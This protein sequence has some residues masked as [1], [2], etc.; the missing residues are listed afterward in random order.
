MTDQ[1]PDAPQPSRMQRLKEY[2]AQ[3]EVRFSAAFFLA[4]FLFD[5]VTLSS[6]DDPFTIIQ[7]VVYLLILNV[8]LMMESRLE[9]QGVEPPRWLRRAWPY[10]G[11]VVHFILGSLLSLYSLYFFKSASLSSSILFMVLMFAALVLNELPQFQKLGL[12]IRWSLFSLC[13]FSFTLTLM[14]VLFGHVGWLPFLASLVVTTAILLAVIHDLHKRDPQAKVVQ[15]ESV[16]P[17]PAGAQNLQSTAQ[18][19]TAGAPQTVV[20][21]VR[22]KAFYLKKLAPAFGV[23]VLFFVFYLFKILPPVP[24]TLQKVGVYHDIQKDSV[25][26]EYLLFRERPWWKFWQNGDQTFYARPGEKIYV[27]AAIYSPTSF[28]DQVYMTWMRKDPELGWQSWQRIPMSIAGGRQEGFRGYTNKAN[29][30]TGTWR[31]VIETTDGREIGR[32][33]FNVYRSDAP[34]E[35]EPER[36]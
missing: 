24:V 18:A 5:V 36:Y 19:P 35:T 8:L 21:E 14:P 10:H 26:D 6:P 3:H 33:Q 15:Q 23:L 16:P 12:K 22:P 28:S 29:Y 30:E 13:I 32:I 17:E 4:G 7:Q 11:L 27:F 2:Y 34:L 25:T 20:R 9:F 1:I 31:T